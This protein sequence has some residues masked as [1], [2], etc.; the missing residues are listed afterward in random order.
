MDKKIKTYVT[1]GRFFLVFIIGALLFLFANMVTAEN[2]SNG[3]KFRVTDITDLKE[4]A[5]KIAEE[6]EGRIEPQG[7]QVKGAKEAAKAVYSHAGSALFQQKV[8]EQEQR[9]M[10]EIHSLTGEL[11]GQEGE[12]DSSGRDEKARQGETFLAGNEKIYIFIS[13]SVP[14][15]TLRNYAVDMDRLKEPNI[16]MVMRG[17]VDGMSFFLPTREFLKEILLRDPA[18]WNKNPKSCE[19]F[20]VDVS[21]DPMLFRTFQIEVVPATVY[22]RDREFDPAGK[23]GMPENKGEFFLVYGDASLRETLEAINREAKVMSVR[24]ILEKLGG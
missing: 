4:K 24:K 21:I 14:M 20:P 15:Q 3:E 10:E 2:T 13:S 22:Y 23:P 1:E 6:L 18:C 11:P 17:F 8:R 7:E 12:G 5:G 9:L 19:A 16:R